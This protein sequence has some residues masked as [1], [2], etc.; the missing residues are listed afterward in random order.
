MGGHHGRWWPRRVVRHT[1]HH[2]HSLSEAS[3]PEAAEKLVYVWSGGLTS[4]VTG[5]G[6][7]RPPVV[8]RAPGAPNT[9]NWYCDRARLRTSHW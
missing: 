1:V 7:P 3:E 5:E 2:S 9:S 4:T 6:S 8:A